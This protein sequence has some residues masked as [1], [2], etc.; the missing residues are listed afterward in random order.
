MISAQSLPR[1]P[2][3]PAAFCKRFWRTIWRSGGSDNSSGDKK[4]NATL[5]GRRVLVVEDEY[6]VAADLF[7]ILTN[8]S[9]TVF[10]PV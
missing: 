8:A 10:G 3:E 4:N 2:I 5:A 7:D 6:L 9:A 1:Q